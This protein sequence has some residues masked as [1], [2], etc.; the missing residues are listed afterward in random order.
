MHAEEKGHDGFTVLTDRPK[1][2]FFK[3][4]ALA[5]SES[6]VGALSEF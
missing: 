2:A 6:I 3:N 4:C 5:D 1:A